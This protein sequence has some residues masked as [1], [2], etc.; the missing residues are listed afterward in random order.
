MPSI[1][2]P[3]YQDIKALN[4]GGSIT[5]TCDQKSERSNFSKRE[6]TKRMVASSNQR[7]ISSAKANEVATIS[8]KLNRKNEL[9][10]QIAR[11][12]EILTRLLES[13]K[14]K[15]EQGEDDQ[16]KSTEWKYNP[17]NTTEQ[18]LIG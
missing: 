16:R 7:N 8:D 15:R 17:N 11:Q 3:R 13:E 6:T 10:K 12:E 5:I 2:Q 18:Y 14:S 4:P 9:N 1:K